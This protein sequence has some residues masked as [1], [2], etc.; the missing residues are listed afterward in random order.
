M[1]CLEGVHVEEILQL[2]VRQI[3]AHLLEA[4]VGQILKSKDVQ[5]ANLRAVLAAA[6]LQQRAKE[7][8]K[9]RKREEERGRERGRG[10]V[11]VRE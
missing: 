11:F 8:K 7:R 2:L 4:V 1:T 9:E 6:L 5:H 10:R 3:D